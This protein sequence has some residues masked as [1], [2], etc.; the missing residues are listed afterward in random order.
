MTRREGILARVDRRR[1]GRG[2]AAA[3]TVGTVVGDQDP[4]AGQRVDAQLCQRY[5]SIATCSIPASMKIR[6]VGTY[7][8]A[9]YRFRA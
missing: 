4:L 6:P 8:D 3:G 7:P 5:F 1:G 9:S 2:Q